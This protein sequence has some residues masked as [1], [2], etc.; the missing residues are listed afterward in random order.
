MH[1][2]FRAFGRNCI[3]VLTK[4]MEGVQSPEDLDDNI[5]LYARG[6]AERLGLNPSK[7]R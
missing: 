6:F 4:Y 3:P 5:L 7:L 2:L 1:Y